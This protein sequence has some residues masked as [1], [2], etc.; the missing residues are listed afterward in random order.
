MAS[1]LSISATAIPQLDLDSDNGGGNEV[2]SG[3]SENSATTRKFGSRT[4]K[5]L[6]GS[7][8]F[9]TF[10]ASNPERP[11]V[12]LQSNSF[13]KLVPASATRRISGPQFSTPNQPFSSPQSSFS[14]SGGFTSSL[15]PFSSISTP[16]RSFSSLPITNSVQ[17]S[18]R[19]QRSGVGLQASRQERQFG[20]NNNNNNNFGGNNNNNNQNGNQPPLFVNQ[21][22][23]P[24]PAFGVPTIVR[25]SFNAPTNPDSDWN[26][27]YETSHGIKQEA[28][29]GVKQVGDTKVVIMRGSYEYIG[30]DGRTYKVDWFADETGFHAEGTHLPRSVPIPFPD[31]QRAVDQQIAFAAQQQRNTGNQQQQQTA[32]ASTNVET[33]VLPPSDGEVPVQA[34]YGVAAEEPLSSY[35]SGNNS[36]YEYNEPAAAVAPVGLYG[37][38]NLPTP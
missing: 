5:K 6:G 30:P 22:G 16:V 33:I 36:D 18:F 29:G 21:F 20:N 15:K 19:S 9:K 23:V 17:N 3:G 8:T 27:A 10:Q 38:A 34:S 28:S 11:F 31:Q 24:G 32:A 35:D 25:Q 7:R 4:F 37:A 12:R 26:Y 13:R 14:N 2:T 1:A